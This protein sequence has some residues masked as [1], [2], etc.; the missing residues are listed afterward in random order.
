MDERAATGGAGGGWRKVC[1]VI[2]PMKTAEDIDRQKRLATEIVQPLLT[3]EFNVQLPDAPQPGQIMRQVIAA[4][5]RAD[6]VVA[7]VTGGNPSVM[8]E[9]G[10]R[11]CIGLPTITVR[12]KQASSDE[13]VAFDIRH[14]RYC[15]IDLDDPAAARETLRPAIETALAGLQN[16]VAKGEYDNPVTEY[17]KGWPM[18]EG[19]PAAGLALGYYINMVK[20]SAQ[21]LSDPAVKVFLL[22]DQKHQKGELAVDQIKRLDIYIPRDLR[23]ATVSYADAFRKNMKAE[24]CEITAPGRRVGAFFIDGSLLDIPTTLSAIREAVRRRVPD[25]PGL[26]SDIARFVLSRE[27]DRFVAALKRLIED[28]LDEPH[29]VTA[30]LTNQVALQDLPAQ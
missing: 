22:D 1:F 17:Y 24:N 7:D 29:A 6:L 28:E 3:D 8:Y 15:A 16:R 13:L 18:I 23:Q 27:I 12:Q 25:D 21:A 14:F 26:R 20:R 30:F 9:L 5:D 4:L 10:I 11:H 19:S 2:G